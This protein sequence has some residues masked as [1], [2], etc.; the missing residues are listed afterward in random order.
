MK[1]SQRTVRLQ[2]TEPLRISRSTMAARDAVWLGIE[3]DGR[4]GH[5]EAVASAYYGLDAA[6]L[7][8]LLRR[9]P[10]ANRPLRRPGDRAG[11]PA[12]G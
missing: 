4:R 5:G 7:G 12:R 9:G 10:H 1:V 11:S 3:H 6:T 2:L 8:R